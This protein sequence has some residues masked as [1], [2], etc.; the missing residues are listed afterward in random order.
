MMILWLA[1]AAL[2]EEPMW[3][4]CRASIAP[5]TLA[6]QD[7]GIVPTLPT[8]GAPPDPVGPIPYPRLVVSE[9]GWRLDNEP[10]TVLPALNYV[11]VFAPADLRAPE[12]ARLLEALHGSG[13]RILIAK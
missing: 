11:V 5:L 2:A 12:V 10:V 8:T 6:D 3:R 4:A 13:A 1:T 9:D 7:A